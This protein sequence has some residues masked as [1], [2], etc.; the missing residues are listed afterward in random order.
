M[1]IFTLATTALLLMGASTCDPAPAERVD[2][3]PPCEGVIVEVM[4][5]QYPDCDVSPPQI[6]V[7]LESNLDDCNHMGGTFMT[8]RFDRGICIDLDY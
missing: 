6:M 1:N 4:S 3:R 7:E 5:G 8:D 2:H